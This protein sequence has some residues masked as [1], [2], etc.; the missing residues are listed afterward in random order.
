M[1]HPNILL[2]T[3]DQQR[4]DAV[5][6]NGT[7]VQT[8]C[9]DRLAAGSLRCHNAIT[10]SPVCMPARFSLAT[11]L[12]PHQMDGVGGEVGPMLNNSGRKLGPETQTWMQC[13]QRA[14]Y[15]NALFG[16]THF[17]PNA[18]DLLA[19][20]ERLRSL[21]FDDVDEIPGPRGMRKAR[22]HM[23]ERWKRLNL[24]E[25]FRADL[26]D[27]LQHN[28][29]VVR[30]SPLPVEE[31]YDSYVAE[32]CRGWI[33]SR[34]EAAEKEPQPW[35]AWLSF[36]G[37]HEPFDTPHPYHGSVDPDAMPPARPLPESAHGDRPQGQL[38]RLPREAHYHGNVD[39]TPDEIARI[40]ADYAAACRLIDDRIAEVIAELERTGQLAH[41]VIVFSSDHGELAGDGGLLYKCCFLDGAVRVPLLISTPA[42]RAAGGADCWRP[43]PWHDIGPTL[44]EIAGG[45]IA[46]QQSAR[47]LVPLL[48]DPTAPY[49]DAAFSE[50]DGEC[51]LFDE[52]WKCALNRDGD[53]YYLNDRQAD[54]DETRNVAGDPA[55]AEVEA[56]LLTRLRGHWVA[57][58]SMG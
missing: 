45:H 18:G 34:A 27:R 39:C 23:S 14:G 58:Q 48:S 29:H 7:W 41:T 25:D 51:L 20:E 42:T 35:F 49:R 10:T 28:E 6:Y 47:S 56:A 26:N 40:R 54:P 32:R 38:D 55:Y 53:V 30:A 1:P 5:G 37:P 13:L 17:Y 36:A 21:G 46:H 22:C 33:G 19:E 57:E 31:F 24:F 43:I 52:R 50:I 8:P 44:V 11:G 12:Y 2:I 16:K 4:W 15:R 3:T 9:L